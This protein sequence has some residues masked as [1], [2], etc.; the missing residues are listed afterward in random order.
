MR[1][2]HSIYVDY[3]DYDEIAHHAGATR[4]ESLASLTGLDH[5]LA[6]LERIERGAP[7]RFHFVL[8]SDH[9]Q[10]QG[11]PFAS[12]YGTDLSELAGP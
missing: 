1:G 6:V 8:L 4:I 2:A 3:V 9:G 5:V 7:R 12:R 11:E 10:S